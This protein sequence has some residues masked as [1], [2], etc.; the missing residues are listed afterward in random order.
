ML[1]ILKSDDYLCSQTGEGEFCPSSEVKKVNRQVICF[2]FNLK[3]GLQR[4]KPFLANFFVSVISIYRFSI[5]ISKLSK[6]WWFVWITRIVLKRWKPY[7]SFIF[8]VPSPRQCESGYSFKLIGIIRIFFITRENFE[9]RG[10]FECYFLIIM[11]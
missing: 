5:W 3:N 4:R 11:T 8:T 10:M 2:T 1:S 7:L 6:R 9:D